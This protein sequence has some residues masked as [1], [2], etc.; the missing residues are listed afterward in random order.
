MSGGASYD[1]E[2]QRVRSVG[3]RATASD[4]ADSI[5]VRFLEEDRQ[6]PTEVTGWLADFVGSARRSLDF[7][8]HD[9]HLS[10]GP[11]T[12]LR[13]MIASKVNA[14]VRVRLVYDAGVTARTSAAI[15]ESI[16]E[17]AALRLPERIRDLGLPRGSARAVLGQQ[18]SMHHKYVVRDGEAVW[19]GSLDLT[20]DAMRRMENLIV[21]VDSPTIAAHYSRDFVQLWGTGKI[22]ASAAPES[23]PVLLRFA[24]APARVEVLFSPRRDQTLNAAIADRVARA[25]RRVVVCATLIASDRLIRALDMLVRR[26]DVELEGAYDG[27]QMAAAVEGWRS[28]PELAW[29]VEA[30][31]RIVDGGR[32]VA[33]QSEP[34]RPG[35]SRNPLH[36]KALVVDNT[37]ITG[38]QDFSETA[39]TDADNVLI[40]ES[41]A[42][43]DEVVAYA[44]RLKSRYAGT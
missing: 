26:G 22:V 13:R 19:T 37:V 33:K 7:A 35:Q 31:D 28:R 10:E 1:R 39:L 27:A 14:G 20:D 24:A 12:M 9:C 8:V 25:R 17:Q 11:A 43:A 16:G 23:Q 30:V 4:T 5:G 3:T 44:R 36:V 15:E 38:S 29:Q 34:Y 41:V 21:T 6:R 40:I 32:F 2:R 42:L 18:A